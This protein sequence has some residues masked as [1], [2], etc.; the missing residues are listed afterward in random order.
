MEDLEMEDLEKQ[1][2]RMVREHKKT[3]SPSRMFDNQ[4]HDQEYRGL[5][6]KL[7]TAYEERGGKDDSWKARILRESLGEFRSYIQHQYGL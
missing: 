4:A 6:E 7:A 2:K 5:L 1:I 3:S